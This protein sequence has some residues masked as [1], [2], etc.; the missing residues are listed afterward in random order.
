LYLSHLSLWATFI[1]WTSH[2]HSGPN[3][4]APGVVI[5]GCNIHDWMVGYIY[6][7]E[8]PYFAKT[9]AQG[10]AVLTDLPARIYVARVWHPQLAVAEDATRKNVD[11]SNAQ[12]VEVTWIV[13]LKPEVKIRRAPIGGGREGY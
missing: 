2:D 4:E 6:V 10:K 12:R 8:S 7:S 13:N 11:A 9:N 3:T 1:G 5:L